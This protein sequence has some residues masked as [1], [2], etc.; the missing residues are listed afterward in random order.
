MITD[1]ETNNNG[2]F[3][4]CMQN[5]ASNKEESFRGNVCD[6]GHINYQIFAHQNVHCH[7]F[8]AF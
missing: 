1:I 8:T 5:R 3:L 4:V 2:N 6:R 7:M